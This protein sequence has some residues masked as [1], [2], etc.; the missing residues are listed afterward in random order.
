MLLVPTADYYQKLFIKICAGSQTEEPLSCLG[1]SLASFVRKRKGEREVTRQEFPTS[2]D[3]PLAAETTQNWSSMTVGIEQ[4][5][6]PKFKKGGWHSREVHFLLPLLVGP[7]LQSEAPPPSLE[8]VYSGDHKC[9][10][11]TS[12]SLSMGFISV[13]GWRRKADGQILEHWNIFNEITR[14]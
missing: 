1:F 6:E 10:S 2:S 3:L 7:Q 9:L 14:R 12:P 5:K 8:T 4:K 11:I 13:S